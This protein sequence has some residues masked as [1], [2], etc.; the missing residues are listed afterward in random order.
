MH[1]HLAPLIHHLRLG[2]AAL[3]AGYAYAALAG[4]LVV[5]GTGMPL[6]PFEPLFV[7]TALL[8]AHGQLRLWPMVVAGAAGDLLGN[9]IGYHIGR[10]VGRVLLDRYGPRWHLGPER[11]AAT[12]RWFWRF[13]GGTL[14]IARFF[15]P[16][17]TPAI[18]LAGLSRM[19]L[20]SYVAW[21]GVADF[22]WVLAWQVA[23]LH[24][25]G[26]VRVAWRRVGIPGAGVAF[27]LLVILGAVI[28]W[29]RWRAQRG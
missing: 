20:V 28:L 24:F 15:G 1:P 26:L 21:C 12:E 19:P 14:F 17:R 25:G 6:V 4:I 5:E 22:L 7:A 8:V 27:A 16:I 3:P 13:G 29:R 10:T 18:L 23:L 11:M 9:V 2:L